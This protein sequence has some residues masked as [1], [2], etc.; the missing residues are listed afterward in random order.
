MVKI[1][2]PTKNEEESL[3]QTIDEI[4]SVCAC[5][6]IVVDA[7]SKD[8]TVEIAKSKNASVIYD[9][10][11]GKGEALRTA[12][13]YA[14]DDIIFV[15]PDGTYPIQKMPQFI[16]ALKIHDSIYGEPVE[17][18]KNAMPW[19][20]HIG[21]RMTKLIFYLLYHTSGNN[22]SGFRALKK[23]AIEKMALESDGF[24]I[25]TEIAAKS[26]RLNLKTKSIPIRYDSRNGASKF[27]SIKDSLVVLRA[28]FKYRINP[29]SHPAFHQ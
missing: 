28:L 12:F 14:D 5:E 4:R 9:H 22:M 24:D 21:R 17:Y 8:R 10:G 7:H 23:S 26:V 6:I 19:Q 20:Y 16:E 2:L 13:A 29:L 3:A 1:I 18:S 11:K 15:D 25:E 27:H